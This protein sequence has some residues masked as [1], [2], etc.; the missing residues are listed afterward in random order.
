M[1]VIRSW[2]LILF[3]AVASCAAGKIRSSYQVYPLRA[4]SAATSLRGLGVKNA[5]IVSKSYDEQVV[6]PIRLT[7]T[8]GS[9][10]DLAKLRVRTVVEGPLA[11]TELKMTFV[12]PRKREIEGRFEITLP[13]GASVARLAMKMGSRWQEAEVVARRRGQQVYES[14]LHK[15]VD[16]VLL[17]ASVGNHFRAR[18]YPIPAK[19]EK[20]IIISYSELLPANGRYRLLLAGLPMVQELDVDVHH[21]EQRERFV[22]ARFV[23]K[24]DLVVK[25]KKAG[26]TAVRA[27]E[28]VMMR[29]IPIQKNPSR[30]GDITKLS[31]LVDS[32]ASASGVYGRQVRALEQLAGALASTHGAGFELE[33]A[34]YDN[35]VTPVF[36]GLAKDYGAVQSQELLSHGALG[37]TN[38][39]AAMR[40]AAKRS[41]RLLLIGDGIATTE[42]RAFSAL[43]KVLGGQSLMRMDALSFAS[44]KNRPLL[45]ELVRSSAQHPGVLLSARH[46]PTQWVQ[47]IAQVAPASVEID[48]AGASWVWPKTVRPTRAGEA[49]TAFA[50]FEE[51]GAARL[52]SIRV[53]R[54][55]SLEDLMLPVVDGSEPLVQRQWAEVQLQNLIRLQREEKTDVRQSLIEDLSHRFRILTSETSFLMLESASDYQRFGIDQ[56]DSGAVLMVDATGLREVGKRR[57]AQDWQLHTL[58][59]KPFRKQRAVTANQVGSGSIEGKV[60]DKSTGERLAGVTIVASSVNRQR[61]YN[62][63]SD[64]GG[65]FKFGDLPSGHYSL[66][67]IYADVKM[68]YDEIRVQPGAVAKIFAKLDLSQLG[69]EA[70]VIRGR[71][72]I[73]TTKT[74]QGVVISRDFTEN[75]PIPGRTFEQAL[76]VA[77]GAESDGVGISFSGSSSMENRYVVDGINSGKQ[78]TS[79]KRPRKDS[80]NIR[81]FRRIR[82]QLAD[83]SLSSA[84]GSSLR[85]YARAP[86]NLLAVTAL[87]ESLQAAGHYK[88]AAR[89]FA[90]ILDL[91]P[92]RADMHR[93]A[94][95][96]LSPLGTIAAGLREHALRFAHDARPDHVHGIRLLAMELAM[97]GNEEKAIVLL[98]A[99]LDKPADRLRR[100]EQIRKLMRYEIGII[101]AAWLAREP[102]KAE[103]LKRIL[104]PSGIL[105]PMRSE[106]YAVLSWES[107]VARLDLQ[108]TRVGGGESVSG[109]KTSIGAIGYGPEAFIVEDEDETKIGISV[110]FADQAMTGYAFAQ[111]QVITLDVQGKLRVD[112]RP[113][114][115]LEAREQVALGSL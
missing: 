46:S 52:K 55:R 22:K 65:G 69:G 47:Q 11:F 100:L 70:V 30:E 16:P 82:G 32:S 45:E 101:A 13:D 89:A 33:V 8:D 112:A 29:W 103:T 39:R 71:A 42:G 12:N 10:L 48:V 19:G 76:S 60:R 3:L 18:V 95:G 31:V 59:E 25:T 111:L 1:R 107:D 54:G 78:V 9:G 36:K 6:A 105:V 96:Y 61:N 85:W 23:G 110:E 97:S 35:E 4:P 7:A 56:N 2:G 63:I 84:L 58:V 81:V 43:S 21:G 73:D 90:S 108:V 80:H 75:L 14:F 5:A 104:E 26:N 93:L 114:V 88:L 44:A 106:R 94:A 92:S 17:E 40:W 79:V 87:G 77:A 91:Y 115:A 20:E 51:A 62:A 113:F 24:H 15:Q 83:G 102:A 49:V 50:K 57:A 72:L 98:L 28:L 41:G 53:D 66:L 109:T 67:L 99:T 64:A 86:G 37:A 74:T 38:L 68:K 34:C 27:G